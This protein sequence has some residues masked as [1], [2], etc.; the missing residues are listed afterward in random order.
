MDPRMPNPVTSVPGALAALM[1]LAKAADAGGLAQSTVDL[2]NLRASQINGCSVCVQMHATDMKKSGQEDERIFAVAAWH[3]A[4]YFTE[5]ER[6]A[7]ALTEHATRLAD[8][9]D[10]VPTEVF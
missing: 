7:L 6:A 9:L 8:R 3:D 2:V 1:D 4:P 10:P 5:E